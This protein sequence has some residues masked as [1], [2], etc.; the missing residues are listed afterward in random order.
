MRENFVKSHSSSV[1]GS[2]DNFQNH[3]LILLG[4]RWAE[5]LEWKVSDIF[6]SP[7]RKILWSTEQNLQRDAGKERHISFSLTLNRAFKCLF[8]NKFRFVATYY[9]LYEQLNLNSEGIQ[10]PSL[11]CF[12]FAIILYLLLLWIKVITVFKRPTSLHDYHFCINIYNNAFPLLIFF[13][14]LE[15]MKCKWTTVKIK[16]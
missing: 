16:T 5:S 4:P 14:L 8:R 3:L 1:L 13:L 15:E 11:D 9:V 7:F 2:D 12:L 6:N 10:I